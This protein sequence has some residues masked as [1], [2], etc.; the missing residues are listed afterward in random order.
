[1]EELN[2]DDKQE[3]LKQMMIRLKSSEEELKDLFKEMVEAR[4]QIKHLKRDIGEL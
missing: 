1:M 2:T 4:R 3:L